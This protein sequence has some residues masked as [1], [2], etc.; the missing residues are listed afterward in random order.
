MLWWN[1]RNFHIQGTLRT[2]FGV[3]TPV[4]AVLACLNSI[5]L[6]KSM[7]Y[8]YEEHIYAYM[9]IFMVYVEIYTWNMYVYSLIL[10]ALFAV[11]CP[12]KS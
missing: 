7:R 2:F 4:S 12:M 6:S 9:H 1:Q 11:L 5:G 3:A 10:S 8:M